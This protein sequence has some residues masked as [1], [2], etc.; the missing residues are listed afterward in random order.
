MVD[1]IYISNNEQL[2]PELFSR[3][4]KLLPEQFH[5]SFKRYIRWQDRQAGLLGKLLLRQLLI[6][7]GIPPGRLATYN[8]DQYG[9]PSIDVP[10]DFNISHS[11][12]IVIAALTNAP[13]IGIDIEKVRDIEPL[14]FSRVFTP[15][16]ANHIGIGKVRNIKFFDV[17]TKKEAAMKA[18]GRGFYLD[19]KQIDTLGK[20]ILIQETDWFSVPLK[21]S[22]DYIC[23]YCLHSSAEQQRLQGFTTKTF[24]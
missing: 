14:E 5:G 19:A 11:D 16:E 24:F 20:S 21:I 6:M 23:H 10:G 9:R 7:N 18:D 8:S 4:E 3:L 2:S 1:I 17:W 12:G 22:A 13:R 15:Q